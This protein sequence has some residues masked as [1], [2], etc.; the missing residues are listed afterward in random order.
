MD[1]TI[2]DVKVNTQVARADFDFP[3]VSG[4]PLP[5]IPM[6]L[7]ELQANEDRVESIL[8][9]YSF[10]Q[11]TVTRE[12]GKDGVLREKE[13]ET[14]ELSFYKGFRITRLVERTAGR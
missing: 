3:Q 2:E 8:D 12:L 10:K 4:Q 13:S 1:V 11:T 6:L 5:D 7:Q 9:N 14:L